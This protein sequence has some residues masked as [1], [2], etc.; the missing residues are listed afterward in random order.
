MPGYFFEMCAVPAIIVATADVLSAQIGMTEYP[1]RWHVVLEVV[2]S[3]LI[4]AINTAILVFAGVDGLTTLCSATLYLPFA[5]KGLL[6]RKY[7]DGRFIFSLTSIALF[8]QF[9]ACLSLVWLDAN[10]RGPLL[11]TVS[12]GGLSLVAALLVQH[13]V[14]DLYRSIQEK[15]ESGWVVYSLLPIAGNAFVLVCFLFYRHLEVYMVLT[16]SGIAFLF[17]FISLGTFF[18]FFK[19]LYESVNLEA[20]VRL[21]RSQQQ[22]QEKL[23]K[24]RRENENKERRI[25]HDQR[26]FYQ[27]M[28]DELDCGEVDEVR[29]KLVR[30][31]G[32]SLVPD[33]DY[34][35]NLTVNSILKVWSYR[36]Q[37][38]GIDIQIRADVPEKLDVD[39]MELGSLVSNLLENAYEA[40]LRL[41][42]S[43]RRRFI[44]FK[45]TYRKGKLI[46]QIKNSSRDDVSFDSS[47]LP[48]SQKHGAGGIGTRSARTSV[49][50]YGG[51]IRYSLADGVFTTRFILGA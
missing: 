16:L 12:L 22:I 23:E 17:A 25:R 28:I 18:Y 10:A 50:R 20:D 51:Q 27:V 11:F 8:I 21:L 2:L 40:C 42:R 15:I 7:S 13:F 3:L 4:S 6:F 1:T 43:E 29:E 34:C 48:A 5:L 32:D 49:E 45:M 24:E 38:Q 46:C 44:D 35:K 30:L 19:R 37:D 47:G 31:R 39:S 9:E 33:F 41:E 14:R 36:A 26:H